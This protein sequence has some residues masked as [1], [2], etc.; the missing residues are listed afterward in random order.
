[1]TLPGPSQWTRE[2]RMPSYRLRPADDARRTG[3][4][5]GQPAT[6]LATA[7]TGTLAG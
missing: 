1:M 5:I 2:V 4:G 7:A 3:D 6:I